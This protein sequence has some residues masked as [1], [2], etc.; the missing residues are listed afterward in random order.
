MPQKFLPYIGN[1]IR[2]GRRVGVCGISKK[3]DFTNIPDL[4]QTFRIY[5]KHSGFITN[6]PD[7]LQT[8]RIC[9]KH[10]GFIR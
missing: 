7:L 9:Y 1:L 4:L 10:S 5:Y 2:M 8:F 6:I 3:G